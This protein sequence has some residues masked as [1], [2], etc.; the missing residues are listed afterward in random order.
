MT[1]KPTLSLFT[2]TENLGSIFM[3]QDG[4]NIKFTDFNIPLSDSSGYTAFDWKGKTRVILV[5]GAMSGEGF[6]GA[7]TNDKIKDFLSAIYGH[8]DISTLQT[9][10]TYTN[11]L[12]LSYTVKIFDFT[13]RRMFQD[14]SRI[15]YT[16]LLKRV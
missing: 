5:Q 14:P 10:L 3:E 13:W 9:S 11:S 16:I 7:T 8:I 6:S 2:G 4:F 12:G 1:T 15:L